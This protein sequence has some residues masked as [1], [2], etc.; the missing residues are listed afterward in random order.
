MP[1]EHVRRRRVDHLIR[2]M[3]A[4]T[5]SARLAH[6]VVFNLVGPA[7]TISRRIPSRQPWATVAAQVIAPTTFCAKLGTRTPSGRT[8]SQSLSTFGGFVT[9]P[10]SPDKKAVRHSADRAG[11]GRLRVRPRH[12]GHDVPGAVRPARSPYAVRRH[13]GGQSR[14]GTH[15]SAQADRGRRGARRARQDLRLDQQAARLRGQG[16]SARGSR[17]H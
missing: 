2:S 9:T 10:R 13:H 14:Q 5:S 4:S 1:A 6:D 17:P 16:R 7:G 3:F 11:G 12:R 15:G 8:K